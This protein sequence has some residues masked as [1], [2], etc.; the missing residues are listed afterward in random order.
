MGSFSSRKGTAFWAPPLD[1]LYWEPTL[2]SQTLHSLRCM[3]QKREPWTS[4]F[5]LHVQHHSNMLL[6]VTSRGSIP[7]GFYQTTRKA[8]SVHESASLTKTIRLHNSPR[9]QNRSKTDSNAA[10]YE[11]CSCASIEIAALRCDH[12]MDSIKSSFRDKEATDRKSSYIIVDAPAFVAI[13]NRQFVTCPCVK[14]QRLN[15]KMSVWLSF[16]CFLPRRIKV[17]AHSR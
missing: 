3:H 14:S 1:V 5:L 15:I 13:E 10:Q 17:E 8:V 2:C 16:H 6:P 7:R 12:R 9:P 4:A 11:A